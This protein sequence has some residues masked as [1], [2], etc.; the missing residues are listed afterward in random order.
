MR[1]KITRNGA[2]SACSKLSALAFLAVSA[3]GQTA[4]DLAAK[5]PSVSAY[6]VR[7]GILM[8]AKYAADGRICELVLE[9]RHYQAGDGVDLEV[10][11][12]SELEKQV[13]DEL[14]PPVER[15]EPIHRWSKKEPKDSWLDP[16]SYMAGGV[17][18]YKRSYENVSIEQHGYYRCHD[19]QT[20]KKTDGK[21][22]CSEGGDEVVVIRWTKRTCSKAAGLGQMVPAGS[23]GVAAGDRGTDKGETEAGKEAK[24]GGSPEGDG[25]SAT[26]GE[27]FWSGTGEGEQDA[28]TSNEVTRQDVVKSARVQRGERRQAGKRGRE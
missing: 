11:F 26:F 5:Y 17:S 27:K 9:P 19:N 1:F 23:G 2:V 16:D 28:A 12:P 15:G 20:T 18:Y 4:A 3:W 7:P 21:L 8:T 10:V 13:I 14:V 6:E 22:D 24:A 25:Q